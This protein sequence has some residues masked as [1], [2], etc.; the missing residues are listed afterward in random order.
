VNDSDGHAAG[1]SLLRLA[2][3]VLRS[4]FRDS[5]TVARVGGDEFV[6]FSIDA[7]DQDPDEVAD[8]LSKELARANE[9]TSGPSQLRWS[10]GHVCF[11][12]VAVDS[13]DRLIS[14]ADRRM[15]AIKR[16]TQ[17]AST[18]FVTT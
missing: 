6:V 18:G 15:Y 8:R 14:E 3:R 7:T 16:T 10:V 11:D 4:T 17:L 1:D 5:D 2:G 13:L 9:T 12:G